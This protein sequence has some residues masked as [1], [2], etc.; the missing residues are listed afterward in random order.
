M[1]RTAPERI[2]EYWQ[3]EPAHPTKPN[4]TSSY[5][6]SQADMKTGALTATGGG[7]WRRVAWNR[8]G[9]ARV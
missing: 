9:S 5:P 6:S 2:L 8:N 7:V 1:Q 3:I 4:L